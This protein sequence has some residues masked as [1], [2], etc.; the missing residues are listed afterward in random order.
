MQRLHRIHFDVLR[1]QRGACLVSIHLPVQ[2]H[3]QQTLQRLWREVEEQLTRQESEAIL[4]PVRHLVDDLPFWESAPLSLS[5]FSRETQHFVLTSPYAVKPRAV[6]GE[7]FY[8]APLLPVLHEDFHFYVLELLPTGSR[9]LS[10]DLYH[11]R[12]LSAPE[13]PWKLAHSLRQEP[14][15]NPDLEA[16]LA[17]FVGGASVVVVGPQMLRRALVIP[18]VRRLDLEGP[19]LFEKVWE[20]LRRHGDDERRQA[21]NQASGQA[22]AP[23][24]I[25][26]AAL[27]D[28]IDTLAVAA[29]VELW[30]VCERGR[31]KPCE[32]PARGLDELVNYAS[33]EVLG[34][35]G[36][37]FVAPSQ[38]LPPTT[39]LL[40]GLKRAPLLRAG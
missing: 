1:Q 27:S 17:A 38:E 28:Q 12:E 9:L 7:R 4:S 18:S 14:Y 19:L 3:R 30:G 36:R 29:G 16:C 22:S 10:G 40:A 21:L 34:N 25:L 8:L 26:G 37:V 39:G 20:Q 11:L 13:L 15:P 31:W 35:G 6:V 5:V 32:G 2:G 33:I 23:Q 24:E